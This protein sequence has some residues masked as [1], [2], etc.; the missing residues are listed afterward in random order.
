MAIL[1]TIEGTVQQG[2][3]IKDALCDLKGYKP[4]LMN[5]ATGLVDVPN[6]ESEIQF[7]KRMIREFIKDSIKSYRLK[8]LEVTKQSIL[9]D[10]T[11]ESDGIEIP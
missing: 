3:L 10:A 6:P 2:V 9:S 4:F 7:A 11:I 1:M 8:N 5:E